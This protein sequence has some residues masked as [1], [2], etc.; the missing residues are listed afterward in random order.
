MATRSKYRIVQDADKAIEVMYKAAKWL[1]ESGKG[2]NKWWQSQNMNRKFM[3]QH[4]EPSE[5]YVVLIGENPV[6]C[7]ILQD[8]Q[9]NQSWE[10]VDKGVKVN[11][12]YIHWLAVHPG[13]RGTGLPKLLVDFAAKR[14]AANGIHLLRLDTN[15]QEAKLR[16][17]YEDLGFELVHI[18]QEDYQQTAFYQKKC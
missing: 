9:R 12:L 6:A 3:L 5:F 4:A 10:S 18:E 1:E 17:I 15:A 7:A 2:P 11:A 16:K 13:Y 8:N 14:A